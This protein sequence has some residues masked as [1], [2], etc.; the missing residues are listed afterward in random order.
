MVGFRVPGAKEFSRMNYSVLREPRV[1]HARH[2]SFVRQ[3]MFFFLCRWMKSHVS[4][5]SYTKFLRNSEETLEENEEP[6]FSEHESDDEF[7]R[8]KKRELLH[9]RR[10]RIE[11]EH[12]REM[13]ELR[14]FKKTSIPAIKRKK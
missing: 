12:R 5:K 11:R 8:K 9:K 13:A 4:S 2:G 1:I 3:D 10:K 7:T 14:R 6:T